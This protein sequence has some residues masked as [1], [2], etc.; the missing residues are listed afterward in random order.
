MGG[1]GI[2]PRD[3]PGLQRYQDT[4]GGTA[5]ARHARGHLQ[6]V[7]MMLSTSK[8]PPKGWLAFDLNIASRLKF[9]S[10]ALPFCDTPE[11]AAY[12]KRMNVRVAAND[13]L[14]SAWTRLVQRVANSRERLT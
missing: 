13:P 8:T 14:Q 12:L 10:V 3:R 11:L 7:Q 9:A 4:V 6:H 5:G 1:P 2:R